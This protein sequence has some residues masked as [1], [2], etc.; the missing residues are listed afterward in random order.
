[1]MKANQFAKIAVLVM[2]G[3]LFIATAGQARV[4]KGRTLSYNKKMV[5]TAIATDGSS[6]SAPVKVVSQVTIH[7]G[8]IRYTGRYRLVVPDGQ[9][10]MLIFQKVTA[11]GRLIPKTVARFKRTAS[12]LGKTSQFTVPASQAAANI[13]QVAATAVTEPI[14]LGIITLD[15]TF[16]IPRFNPL[17]QVDNDTDGISDLNDNDDDDDGIVD[18]LDDDDDGNGT[19]DQ[20]EDMDTDNDNRPNMV[21]S[22]DDNDGLTDKADL[23][24]DD[25]SISDWDGDTDSDSDSIQD[26]DDPD[27][28]NDGIEDSQDEDLDGD[29]ITDLDENDSDED[30]IPDDVDN[31]DDNDGIEDSQDN[32]NNDDG[33]L[34]DDEPDLDE[35][36]VP[37][38][39]EF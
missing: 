35:D 31:D 27:D 21:D 7:A 11:N 37:D 39:S 24:D 15:N 1:M 30:G 22:D 2:I 34:D 23:D 38:D 14:N 10:V 25:D 13:G 8:L 32:D 18:R 5:A 6:V 17:S 36:G 16:A 28:D 4:I 12:G 19:I 33:V 26:A 3:V 9:R 29:G 20:N